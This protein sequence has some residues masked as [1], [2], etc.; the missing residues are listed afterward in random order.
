MHQTRPR[1]K[2]RHEGQAAQTES[3][4]G[5]EERLGSLLCEET[6]TEIS[7]GEESVGSEETKTELAAEIKTNP[8]LRSKQKCSLGVS[9][10]RS[11]LLN[12]QHEP[13]AKR[14]SGLKN[15]WYRMT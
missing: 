8:G 14:F 3:L 5:S 12:R 13:Q 6:N 1:T 4:C 10:R 9:H 2:R 15:T 11:A 7:G